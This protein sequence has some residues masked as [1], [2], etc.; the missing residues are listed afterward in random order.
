MEDEYISL[1]LLLENRLALLFSSL[2]NF[3]FSLLD[4]HFI[5]YYW[6]LTMW[7]IGIQEGIIFLSSLLFKPLFMVQIMFERVCSFLMFTYILSLFS[8]SYFDWNP[9]IICALIFKRMWAV[10]LRGEEKAII[11][12]I[13][14]FWML[15]CVIQIHIHYIC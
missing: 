4:L 1:L 11:I 12:C 13:L 9:K 15:S 7:E 5:L 3:E 2:N 14:D 10:C 6:F 8:F